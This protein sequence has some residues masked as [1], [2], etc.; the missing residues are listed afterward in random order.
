MVQHRFAYKYHVC[1]SYA[2][3]RPTK[4]EAVDGQA[5]RPCAAAVR[6]VWPFAYPEIYQFCFSQQVLFQQFYRKVAQSEFQEKTVMENYQTILRIISIDRVL[7]FEKLGVFFYFIF[8]STFLKRFLCSQYDFTRVWL[9]YVSEFAVF[10][11]GK[12]L[13]KHKPSGF[14]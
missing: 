6:A 8:E 12:V 5:R 14:N 7:K 3:K 10:H 4:S 9:C 2:Q 11:F 1:Q 13:H